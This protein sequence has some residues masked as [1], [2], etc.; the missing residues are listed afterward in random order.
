M[1]SLTTHMV[2]YALSLKG[3]FNMFFDN[4]S[5]SITVLTRGTEVARFFEMAVPQLRCS[6][7]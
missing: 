3:E 6:S 7:L 4:D 2:L 1:M 5:T